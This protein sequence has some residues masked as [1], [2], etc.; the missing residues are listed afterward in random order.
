MSVFDLR[1]GGCRG[2]RG[3]IYQHERGR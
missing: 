3:E 2:I 1:G